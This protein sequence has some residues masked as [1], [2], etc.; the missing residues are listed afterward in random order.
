M[1]LL[2]AVANAAATVVVTAIAVAFAAANAAAIALACTV[3]ISAASTDISTGA[4]LALLDAWACGDDSLSKCDTLE[5][6]AWWRGMEIYEL[7]LG[8]GRSQMRIRVE[9]VL[10]KFSGALQKHPGSILR[11]QTL[12]SYPSKKTQRRVM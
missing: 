6:E 3:T 1:Q 9:Q 2:L 11:P 5:L 4:L 10:S 7:E 12:L 8:V